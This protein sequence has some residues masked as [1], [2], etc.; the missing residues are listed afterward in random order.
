M[1]KPERLV[2]LAML[3]SSACGGRTDNPGSATSAGG[4]SSIGGTTVT[5]GLPSTGGSTITRATSC[6]SSAPHAADQ[7]L[8]E[9]LRCSY[10]T[11]SC[12]LEYQCSVSYGFELVGG[13]GCFTGTGGTSSTGGT[14]ATGATL[15][16]TGGTRPTGGMTSIGGTTPTGGSAGSGCTG[17]FEEIQSK[18][19][20][21]VAQMAAIT[22]PPSDAGN[23]DCQIDVTEVT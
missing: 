11:F 7:C 15:E 18:S 6:P 1:Q 5:G 4:L 17:N 2:I 22:G 23:T 19:G 21:C 10:G 16:L 14:T 9:G 12:P 13:G 3:A 20:L 8:I